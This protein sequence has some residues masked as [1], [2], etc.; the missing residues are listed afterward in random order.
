M[1]A[2][3]K[4]VTRREMGRSSGM[5]TWAF[6]A[7]LTGVSHAETGRKCHRATP[8][9]KAS[10]SLQLG[11]RPDIRKRGHCKKIFSRRKWFAFPA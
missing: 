11:I 8:K 9:S 3:K 1:D 10:G 2:N 5:E 7:R 4:K 6:Q